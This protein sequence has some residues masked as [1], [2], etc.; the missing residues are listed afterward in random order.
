[1]KYIP[2]IIC[3]ILLSNQSFADHEQL[4]YSAPSELPG[5]T[6]EMK[7]AGYWISRHPDPDQ[8]IMNEQ[9]INDFNRHNQEVLG[10]TK[11]LKKFPQFYDGPALKEQLA[12]KV[13]ELKARGLFMDDGQA[14]PERFFDEMMAETAVDTI[15]KKIPVEYGVV[16]RF[17]DQRFLPTD[18]GLYAKPLDIDFDELQNSGLDIGIP[19]IVLHRSADRRWLYA[20]S[21]LS[22]G[23]VP[24]D[25]IA[26]CSHQQFKQY[27][28]MRKFIVVTDATADIYL[29]EALT[30]HYD[31]VRM[32]VIL[33]LAKKADKLVYAVLIPAPTSEGMMELRTAYIKKSQASDKFLPHTPRTI[34]EQAFKLLNKPYGWGDMYGEQDCSRFLQEVFATVGINLTRDS[35]NQAQVGR[36]LARFD[37]TVDAHQK[38]D[39]LGN[40]PGASVIL[41]MKGHIM[42]YLG[43]VDEHPY[44]IHSVWGYREPS[45]DEDVIRVL[46]RVVVSDLFLGEGSKKGSL[47]RRLAAVVEIKN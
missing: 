5:V 41:P 47:L 18:L 20:V 24:A 15:A 33:P 22:D 6:R 8:L 10:L 45:Q 17:A 42:L 46:N 25:T 2:L 39:I 29:D 9:A 3:L 14:A 1:M 26:L 37:E 21:A 16:T 43:T 36:A 23:W 35:K 38:I 12:T 27:I 31:H 4:Y 28:S 40:I 19:V 11:D 32:G 30:Q 7:T 44:A 34:F 13:L